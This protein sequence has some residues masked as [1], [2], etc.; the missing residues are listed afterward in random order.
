MNVF[1]NLDVANDY[2][3]YY[4]TPIG[5][6]VDVIEKSIITQALAKFPRG[7]MLEVGCGTGHWTQFFVDE[8]FRVTAMD[9]SEN[10]LK[11]AKN[12]DV[13]AEFLLGDALA[14]PFSDNHF[15]VVSAITMLEFV[16]NQTKALE[17]IYRVL[18]KNGWLILGCLNENSVIGKNKKHDET[19]K[20]AQ[21]LSKQKL[22][23]IL[24]NFHSIEFKFGVYLDSDFVL[25]HDNNASETIEPV[26][27]CVVAQKL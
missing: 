10:M 16:D 25:T 5:H 19:F 11:I 6:E 15:T 26:F 17:E 3:E 21:F 7:E 20:N 22:I 23:S 1:L 4:Y 8:G 12:K 18:K 9:V 14:L 27:I 13:D 24:V 2:D